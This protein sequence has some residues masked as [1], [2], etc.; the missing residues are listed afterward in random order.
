MSLTVPGGYMI[1]A[2][3]SAVTVHQHV[4]RLYQMCKSAYRIAL[5]AIWDNESDCLYLTR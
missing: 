3:Y 5:N 1:A 2:A 4:A